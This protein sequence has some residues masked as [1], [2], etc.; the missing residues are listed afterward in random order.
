MHPLRR[1]KYLLVAL[2]LTIAVPLCA[3]ADSTFQ[4]S[5]VHVFG[6]D[7]AGAG[8]LLRDDDSVELRVAMTCL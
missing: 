2:L 6:T 5:N 4:A 7:I 1:T 8:T 3:V